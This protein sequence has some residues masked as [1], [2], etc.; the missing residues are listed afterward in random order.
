MLG[1]SLADADIIG[2]SQ[3]ALG[4]MDPYLPN[5]RSDNAIGYRGK[6]GGVTVGAT[7][8]LGRDVSSAGG[9][10]AR[11]TARA[12][13]GPTPVLAASGRLCLTGIKHSF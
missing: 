7:Y 6:F 11:P 10:G 1:G 2:P 12:K 3:F 4:S 8:S 13:A 9:P 5:A